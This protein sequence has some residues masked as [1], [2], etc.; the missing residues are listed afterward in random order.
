M[1]KHITVAASTRTL[2]D[3]RKKAGL[4][5]ARLGKMLGLP[6]AHISAME[7]GRIDIRA[8]TL[9]EWSRA[10]GAELLVVPRILVPT[11]RYLE[12]G[13][14]GGETPALYETTELDDESDAEDFKP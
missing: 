6:Q 12:R 7:S 8:S 1:P 11:I 2:R 4:T 13:P 10:V 14:T 5:Q 9:V 3:S